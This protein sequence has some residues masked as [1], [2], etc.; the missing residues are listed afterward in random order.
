MMDE[1]YDQDN[2]IQSSLDRE[3]TTDHG[4]TETNDL[5]LKGVQLRLDMDVIY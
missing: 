2:H 5:R 1:E 4:R 3:A